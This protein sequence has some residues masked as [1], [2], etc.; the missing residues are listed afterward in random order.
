MMRAD[1]R[2]PTADECS[3][4]AE[5][6]PGVYAIWY[7]QM[8]GYHGKAVVSLSDDGCFDAYV[9]H[10]GEFPFGD[11][12]ESPVRIHHCEAQQFIEFGQTIEGM[13]GR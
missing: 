12:G 4:H 2:E 8:G 3:R 7:P 13:L 10:D 6:A 1:V 9:W 11:K 5:I